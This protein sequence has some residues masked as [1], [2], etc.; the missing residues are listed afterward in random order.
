MSDGIEQTHLLTK[1]REKIKR[2]RKEKGIS[3]EKMAEILGMSKSNYAYMEQGKIPFPLNRF[4]TIIDKLELTNPFLEEATSEQP[5][6]VINPNSL[7]NYFTQ[8][9]QATGQN[10]EDI[11]Q[12]KKNQAQMLEL[13]QKLIDQQN[14]S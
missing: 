4:L 7:A 12:I 6:I 8:M 11:K 13:L 14:K 5:Q 9:L 2:V 3:Q 1:I 10:T